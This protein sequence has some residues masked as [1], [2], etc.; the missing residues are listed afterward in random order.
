M[1]RRK[2]WL[3]IAG[4]SG[5]RNPPPRPEA[6]PNVTHYLPQCNPSP[7]FCPT[8]PAPDSPR[9]E[10]ARPHWAFGTPPTTPCFLP[11]VH[12]AVHGADPGAEL[13]F[14]LGSVR[15]VCVAVGDG[16]RP[17]G[18]RWPAV[19]QLVAPSAGGRGNGR[20]GRASRHT[21]L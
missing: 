4:R 7:I 15:R 18:S 10:F 16:G 13:H 14:R 6:G 9:R 21:H 5:G 20:S 3:Q 2:F 8:T 11:V 17:S 12:A 19:P 1:G